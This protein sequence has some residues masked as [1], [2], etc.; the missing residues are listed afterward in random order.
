MSHDDGVFEA[1]NSFK[2]FFATGLPSP[3]ERPM[4]ISIG[5]ECSP[6]LPF[7]CSRAFPKTSEIIVEF[8][9]NGL[10]VLDAEVACGGYR[11]MLDFLISEVMGPIFRKMCHNFYRGQGGKIDSLLDSTSLVQLDV[12]LSKILSLVLSVNV[13][14]SSE[15]LLVQLRRVAGTEEEYRD[16]GDR[17]RPRF[18]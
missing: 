5:T 9:G 16:A 18:C 2:A 14:T 12:L 6:S 1:A 7:L 4:Q 8:H 10:G 17:V 13:W 3:L 15:C 11:D